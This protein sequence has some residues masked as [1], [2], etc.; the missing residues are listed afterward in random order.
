MDFF[1]M[2]HKYQSRYSVVIGGDVYVYKY[3]MCNIDQSFLSFQPKHTFIGKSKICKMTE[4]SGAN[5]SSDFDRNTFL[6]ECQ[7]NEYVWFSGREIIKF[8]TDDSFIDYISLMGKNMSPYTFSIGENYTYFISTSLK[9]TENDKFEKGTSLNATKNGLYPFDY[10]LEKCGLGSFKTLD[11]TQIQI[12]CPHVEEHTEDED[13]VWLKRMK[14]WLKQFI[15]METMKWLNFLIKSVLYV[16]KE[17]VFRQC[18][19]QC[20]CDQC[21]QNKGDI[22]I[23]KCV[24]CRTW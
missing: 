14:I 1:I 12:C 4:I 6:P 18:I 15:I 23:L 21:Y 24:V 17:I 8:K 19:H 22:D 20:I 7:D 10:Q 5:D 2:Q 16:T 11:C 9:F 3:E 13:H